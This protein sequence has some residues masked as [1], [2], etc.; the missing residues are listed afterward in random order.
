VLGLM[1]FIIGMLGIIELVCKT[2][3][4]LSDS[5]RLSSGLETRHEYLILVLILPFGPPAHLRA[6]NFS[7][8]GV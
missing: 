1:W 3:F 6:Q 2:C 5:N 8:Q 4:M 7:G